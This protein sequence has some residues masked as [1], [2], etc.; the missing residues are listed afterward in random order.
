MDISNGAVG[1]LAIVSSVFSLVMV[2]FWVVVAWR[3][4]RALE[5]IDETLR[6]RPGS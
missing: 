1:A 2:V 4:M 3:G 5:G 6:E